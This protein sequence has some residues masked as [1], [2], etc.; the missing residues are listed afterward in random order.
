MVGPSLHLSWKELACKD[1][2]A[3]PKEWRKDRAVILA[4]VFELIRSECGHKPITILSAYRTE[5]YN[6]KVGGVKNSQHVQGRALDLKP[7]TG[8]TV[9]E[10]HKRIVGLAKAG[11]AI[12]GIGEYKTFVHVDIRPATKLARWTGNGTSDT[13]T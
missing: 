1:G 3:Y 12:K 7:P 13:L 6:K 9:K 5:K 10:F 8:M 11:T 4:E 2:T